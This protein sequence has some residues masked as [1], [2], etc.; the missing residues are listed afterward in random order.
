MSGS[1]NAEFNDRSSQKPRRPYRATDE[2]GEL[3]LIDN[4]QV[5]AIAEVNGF[6][7]HGSTQLVT[8]TLVIMQDGTVFRSKKTV[9]ETLRTLGLP[10][11][12]YKT[13]R[14][15]DPEK[16]LDFLKKEVAGM[17]ASK[18][19]P[20]GGPEEVEKKIDGDKIRI[21]ARGNGTEPVFYVLYKDDSW[22]QVRIESPKK[23]GMT[24]A[25]IAYS[26]S[27]PVTTTS[28][29][30]TEKQVGVL[31]VIR[32]ALEEAQNPP[33]KGFSFALDHYDA[34][35]D[36]IGE[37][38]ISDADAI[39]TAANTGT[40]EAP[41]SLILLTD[42]KTYTCPLSLKDLLEKIRDKESF[43][44]VRPL[45]QKTAEERFIPAL[46]AAYAEGPFKQ[47]EEL[48]LDQYQV[49]ED[50]EV[51]FLI[52]CP[53]K[54]DPRVFVMTNKNFPVRSKGNL[55]TI[56]PSLVKG[57][58]LDAKTSAKEVAH[59]FFFIAMARGNKAGL[60]KIQNVFPD[61]TFEP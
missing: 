13:K 58:K 37:M 12:D 27:V 17:Q 49:K 1:N 20:E 11:T 28:C 42:G 7:T 59:R 26:R 53:V 14:E 45:D 47:E 22:D 8:R 36:A 30:D 55:K 54:N 56:L 48:L 6:Y 19:L 5:V 57:L 18:E 31:N 10:G 4:D 16:V 61:I 23:P 9:P 43:A 44:A 3:W 50:D 51:M 25:E 15:K 33:K 32:R 35:E 41:E 52:N 60:E 39:I 40:A 21:L 34:Q 29:P 24:I 2:N 46:D 38:R